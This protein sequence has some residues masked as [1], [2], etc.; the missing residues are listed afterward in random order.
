MQKKLTAWMLILAMLLTLGAGALADNEKVTL[1]LYGTAN[2]IDVGPDGKMDLVSGVE[3]PGYK[4]IIARWNELHPDVEIVVETCPWDSWLTAI[5]TA[6][7]AGG[8]DVI[9]HG[10]TLTELCEP[11]DP[12]LEKDPEFAGKIF[13]TENKRFGQLDKTMVAGL[14]YVIEPSIAYIDTEILAHYGVA[15]PEANWTWDQLIEIAEKCTGT[16]PVTG[17]Q[18]Y[19]V[20]LC[21]TNNQNIFQNYY[22]MAMAYNAA[23]ITYGATPAESRIDVKGEKMLDIFT[24]L[25]RL[26]ACCAPNVREGVNVVHDLTPENDTAIRWR[27]LAYDQYRK[28]V[29][30]GIQDRFAFI[31]LPVIEQGPAVGAQSTYFGSYNMAICNTSK[32]K[33][34]AWEFIKFMVTD[35]AAVEWTLATGSIPNCKYGMELLKEKMGEK[36]NACIQVLSTL[37]DRYCNT[38]NENYDNVNFGTFSTTLVTILKDL[39]YGT[40]AADK[41]LETWQAAI[42]EYMASIK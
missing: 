15:V 22:Q 26:A 28:A 6:V 25:Q 38:T 1:R 14:Q 36:A 8:V 19:G 24:K 21:Y 13:A 41:A 33:D 39:V 5:Q 10:A 37:P 18:T 32:N 3:V 12:Y 40:T 7:L 31:P 29:A 42:D 30:S 17:K 27:T 34:M 35:K 2:F 23:P 9:L 4:E 16:D 20:Q 11:L